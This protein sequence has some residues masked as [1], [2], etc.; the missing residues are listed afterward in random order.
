MFVVSIQS[1]TDITG[2]NERFWVTVVVEWD[3]S[4]YLGTKGTTT[5]YSST[6]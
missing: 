5:I 3:W 6:P 2:S 1:D 4:T